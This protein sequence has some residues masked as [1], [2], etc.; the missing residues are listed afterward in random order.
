MERARI[1]PATAAAAM[2]DFFLYHCFGHGA[3]GGPHSPGLPE[4]LWLVGL[5]RCS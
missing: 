4:D 3:R 5:V 1:D 2:K